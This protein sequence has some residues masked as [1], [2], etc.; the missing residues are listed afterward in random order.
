MGALI[1]A[2]LGGVLAVVIG[3]IILVLT[4]DKGEETQIDLPELIGAGVLCLLII[5]G[6]FAVGNSMAKSSKLDGFH[7]F[8]NGSLM[9]ANV[10][11]VACDRD[12]SCR[13]EYN[14]DPYTV[15]ID[16]SYTDSKGVRHTS[17][18]QETRYHHCPYATEEFNYWLV[19]DF[20]Y[21]TENYDIYS[22]AFSEQPQE[23]RGGE[24]LPGDVLRGEPPV[25][26]D[27]KARIDAGDPLGAVTTDTYTNYI[28]ATDDPLLKRYSPDVEK[29]VKRKLLPEHTANWK[30][31][32]VSGWDA[33]KFHAVGGA[34]VNAVEWNKAVQQFNAALGVS[35]QGDLHMVVVPAS[36][37]ENSESYIN[38]LVAN[39]QDETYGKW[40]LAKNGVALAVGVSDDG[41][42]VEWVRVKTGMP[43]GN[44]QMQASLEG[45]RDVPFDVGSF[46]GQPKAKYKK[47]KLDYTNSGGLVEDIVIF[48]KTT[49][50]QRACMECK[51]KTDKGSSY[52][53]LEAEVEIPT[54]VLIWETIISFILC[55]GV[56]VFMYFVPVRSIIKD[57]ASSY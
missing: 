55:A 57:I 16:D 54:S 52:V 21:K 41:K 1:P 50:F 35:R 12:G 6:T 45:I 4:R 32:P 20:G 14:C 38:S 34:K 49:Q 13:N 5:F 47:A 30:D 15:T 31:D 11:R 26:K 7:Q 17:S 27:A 23:W 53:Y 48:D 46:L 2:L 56:L 51:D 18:H 10:E 29:Y 19:A 40:S 42:T 43:V 25:W 8:I 24:G 28:L 22:G 44:G 36:K 37:I 39:W 3:G 33:T 9:Q